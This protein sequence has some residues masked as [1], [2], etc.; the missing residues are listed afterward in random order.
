MDLRLAG[1]KA[2]VSGSTQGIGYA[3]TD[4]PVGLAA[5]MLG[6]PGF[7]RWTYDDTDPE[8]SADAGGASHAPAEVVGRRP[9]RPL[10]L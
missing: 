6:H 2:F 10:R 4:S 5:W 3:I 1:K 8:K 9:M 7:S